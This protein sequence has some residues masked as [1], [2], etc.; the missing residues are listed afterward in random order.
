MARPIEMSPDIVGEA[1]RVYHSF[2]A[3]TAYQ[4]NKKRLERRHFDAWI[5]TMIEYPEVIILGIFL[6]SGELL[7]YEI[8]CM[9]D[10]VVHIKSI[11]NSEKGIEL[12][13]PDISIHHYKEE[14][15]KNPEIR[16]IF[17][18]FWMNNPSINIYKLK[19][20]ARVLTLPAKVDCQFPILNLCKWIRPTFPQIRGMDE[21]QVR[22]SLV[23]LGFHV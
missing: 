5:N 6:G 21:S 7:S 14:L 20:G 10:N 23:K 8:S 16:F 2:Y 17:D 4:W 1:F 22:Q 9:V 11:I 19:R 13:A 18:G 3:R 15:K 12:H